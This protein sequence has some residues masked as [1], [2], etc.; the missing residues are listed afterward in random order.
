MQ[1]TEALSKDLLVVS[2]SAAAVFALAIEWP[3]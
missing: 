2:M 3:A 1:V